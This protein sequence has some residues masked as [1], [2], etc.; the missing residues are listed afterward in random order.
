MILSALLL[1]T[2]WVLLVIRDELQPEVS[3]AEL[4]GTYAANYANGTDL[5]QLNSDGTYVHRW[6][7]DGTWHSQTDKWEIET[8]E[9]CS[10]DLHSYK[11]RFPSQVRFGGSQM[12]I[13]RFPSWFYCMHV[14]RTFSG[15]VRIDASG[16]DLDDHYNRRGNEP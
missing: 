7:S 3:R 1:L 6:K 9:G 14:G 2:V 4:I 16:A 5:L 12:S 11:N 8:N 15:R 10:L 13:E